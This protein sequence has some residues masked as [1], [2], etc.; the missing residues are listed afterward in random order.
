LASTVAPKDA[1]AEAVLIGSAVVTA[2]LLTEFAVIAV[3]RK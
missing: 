3:T 2:A 1:G